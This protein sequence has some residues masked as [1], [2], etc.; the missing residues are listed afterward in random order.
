MIETLRS[1]RWRVPSP[2]ELNL[3]KPV[4]KPVRTTPRFE[5]V[6]LESKELK[7]ENQIT[8][9]PDFL[10]IER[11]M[12]GVRP[13]IER[14]R[15]EGS[16]EQL[17]KRGPVSLTT[18]LSNPL[19]FPFGFLSNSFVCDR[20]FGDQDC[21]LIDGVKYNSVTNYLLSK[22]LPGPEG[23]SHKLFLEHAVPDKKMYTTYILAYNEYLVDEI[24]KKILTDLKKNLETGR[25]KY[26][27]LQNY[28]SRPEHYLFD[29]KLSALKSVQRRSHDQGSDD[30]ELVLPPRGRTR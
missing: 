21:L 10:Q 4:R 1:P 17:L 29:P 16:N 7:S 6:D 5:V 15:D 28:A 27:D 19:S 24:T 26:A 23:S 30:P 11:E 25:G 2:S 22:M 14:K 3:R 20:D 18:E 13:K 8:A 12:L 9:G